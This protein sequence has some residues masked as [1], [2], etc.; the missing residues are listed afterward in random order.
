MLFGRGEHSDGVYH[1]LTTTSLNLTLL[2]ADD[3]SPMFRVGGIGIVQVGRSYYL[4]CSKVNHGTCTCVS[5]IWSV[6]IKI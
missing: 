5:N 6:G 4:L 1:S 2:L 3:F